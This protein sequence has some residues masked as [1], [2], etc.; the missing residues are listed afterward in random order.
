MLN[1]TCIFPHRRRDSG[2]RREKIKRG[3]RKK[4]DCRRDRELQPDREVQG[5]MAILALSMALLHSGLQIRG[6]DGK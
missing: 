1:T 3:R 4:R 6:W 5:H 2:R